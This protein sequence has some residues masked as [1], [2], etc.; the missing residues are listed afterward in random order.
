[1]GSFRENKIK[2]AKYTHDLTVKSEKPFS[3]GDIRI[4]F[5]GKIPQWVY[6]YTDTDDSSLN[7]SNS[8]QTYGFNYMCEGIYAGFHANNSNNVTASYNFVI[9]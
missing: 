3:K 6:D 8:L 7:A 5:D 1:M 4:V 9:K 2:S